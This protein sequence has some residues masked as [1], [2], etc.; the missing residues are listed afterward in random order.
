MVAEN[1]F[2]NVLNILLKEMEA[3]GMV[4]PF[5]VDQRDQLISTVANAITDSLG[6]EPSLEQLKDKQFQ[7]TLSVALMAENIHQLKSEHNIDYKKWFTPKLEPRAKKDLE[8]E[9]EKLL[10]QMNELN[11]KRQ[12]SSQQIKLLSKKIMQEC[13]LDDP[14]ST[15]KLD[16][17]TNLEN[18]T[19]VNTLGEIFSEALRGLYGTDPRITGG[20]LMPVLYVVGNLFGIEDK[21]PENVNSGAPIDEFNSTDG[22]PDPLGIE[23]INASRLLALGDNAMVNILVAGANHDLTKEIDYKS[24]T[25]LATHPNNNIG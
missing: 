7:K 14:K 25:P 4:L 22:H 20:H 24:P 16:N 1:K 9:L 6:G 21:N 11:P 5:S 17:K 19:L 13:F 12:L 18:D 15:L 23:R 8:Q 2:H 3:R 10:Q